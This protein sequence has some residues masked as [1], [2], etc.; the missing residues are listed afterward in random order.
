MKSSY[1]SKSSSQSGFTLIG[2]VISLAIGAIAAVGMSRMLASSFSFQGKVERD[3]NRTALKNL[4]VSAVSCRDT[5]PAGTCIPGDLVELKRKRADGTVATLVSSLGTGTRFGNIAV[6][7]VCGADGESVF[8]QAARLKPGL[9]ISSSVLA[10]FLPD[11]FDQMV[12]DWDN[13]KALLL[14]PGLPL[15]LGASNGNGPNLVSCVTRNVAFIPDTTSRV[16]MCPTDHPYFSGVWVS[17]ETVGMDSDK[18]TKIQC[19][20]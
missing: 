6:R 19:C 7:A 1:E 2:A 15:C 3:A 16:Q 9:P 11:P 13:P 14:A 10:S 12:I 8:A 4:I 5:L 17:Q 18:I 20:S